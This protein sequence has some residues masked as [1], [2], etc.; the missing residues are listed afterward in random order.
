MFACVAFL[1][2][3][4]SACSGTDYLNAIP[5]KS[6]AIISVDMQQM[7][8]DDHIADKTGM[9]QSLLHV[10]DVSKCGIDVSEKMYLFESAD[11]N[12]GLCAKVSDDDDVED[13][14]SSLAK[15]HICTPVTERKGFHFTV[16]KDSWILGYSDKAL[17]VMGPVVADAQAQL[18]QQMAKYLKADEDEGITVSPMFD[19]LE[20]IGSPMAMVAQAQALP[21]KFVAPFTLGAPKDSDPSQVV[22]AAEMGVKDGILQ[23][24]GETFSFNKEIDAALQ[25]AAKTYRPIKGQYVKSMPADALAGIFMNVKGEEFLPMMQSNRSLQTLLMGINQ[26]VDMDNIIRSVDGDMAI[27]MPSL[28]DADMKMMM[29]AKLAHSKWLGDVDYWKQSCPAGAK[30]ANWGKNAYFYT[31]GKTSFYFG[32]TDNLQFYSGSDELLAQYAVKPSNH[33]IPAKVQRLIIGQKLA[34][35]VNLG[36]GA[37]SGNTGSDALSAVTGLLSPIFGNLNTVV[38]TLK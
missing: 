3:M 7:A 4:L 13:W 30:I 24:K 34:M 20:S 16:L 33:P 19:R 10:D 17:L 26:A 12:L 36:N 1:M 35:V 23:I 22:I 11:G 27:V 38:Y 5:K 9:L 32:V 29:G 2:G 21:E 18:Q 8:G 31:D 28:T 6:T 15:Q 14:L 25:K 37:G